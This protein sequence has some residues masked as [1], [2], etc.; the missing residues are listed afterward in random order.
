MYVCLSL[1]IAF[2]TV[3]HLLKLD[4]IRKLQDTFSQ[5]KILKF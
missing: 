4:K 2:K 3:T 5:G 1:F